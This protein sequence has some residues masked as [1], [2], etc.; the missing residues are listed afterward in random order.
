[1]LFRRF[2]PHSNPRRRLLI[3]AVQQTAE[4]R[5]AEEVPNHAQRP[6][7][8]VWTPQWRKEFQAGDHQGSVLQY[9]PR[10]LSRCTPDGEPIRKTS[11][12]LPDSFCEFSEP[13]RIR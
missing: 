2:P 5:P 9:A 10:G 7:V 3:A 6:S 12:T 8:R 1:M 13:S 4:L 11:S